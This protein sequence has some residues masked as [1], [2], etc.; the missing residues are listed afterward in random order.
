MHRSIDL[1]TSQFHRWHRSISQVKW[2]VHMSHWHVPPV[3]LTCTQASWPVKLK[4]TC[5]RSSTCAYLSGYADTQNCLP[6]TQ[7]VGRVSGVAGV[8]V[9]Y[10]LRNLQKDS[11]HLLPATMIITRVNCVLQTKVARPLWHDNASKTNFH[12]SM[13]LWQLL[14]S[15]FCFLV[16]L[17]HTFQISVGTL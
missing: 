6:T 4:L 13:P 17:F 15:C 12:R 1:C 8:S 16:L 14:V 9:A 5:D 10:P 7:P 11:H 2:P 3:K